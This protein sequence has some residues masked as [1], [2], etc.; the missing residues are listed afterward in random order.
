M[1]AILIKSSGEAEQMY[2][3]EIDRPSPGPNEVLVRIAYTA[4]NRADILQRMG[5]YPVP[6]GDSPV[7]GLEMS[8]EIVMAGSEVRKWHPG[9]QVFGLLNGGGYAEYAIIHED[10]AMPIP[11]GLGLKEA[12]AIPEVF[13][14][15]YQALHWIGKMKAGDQVLIHAGASGVGT[16]ALQLAQLAGAT[17]LVTASAG[18]HDICRSLGAARTIDYRNEDFAEAVLEFTGSRGVDIILDFIAA[19]Y[20]QQNLRSL[21][22]DGRI[23][24]LALMGGIKVPDVNLAPI[25]MKRLQITGST[26]R[27][28]SLEYKIRLTQDLFTYTR[29]HFASGQLRPIID[30]VFPWREVADAHRYMEANRNQGKILLML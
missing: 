27:N 16:A 5:Q 29:E 30:T 1:Q 11:A 19:N 21:A 3:G 24:M 14:T 18:K 7:M 10:M 28:R 22:V 6:P 15:A 12:A 20:F 26:L 17:S 4:L 2:F 9:D 13:L 8:G 25:L 23:I